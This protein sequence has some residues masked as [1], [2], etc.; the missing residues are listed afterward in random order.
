MGDMVTRL[1]CN[2]EHVDF[3]L[4]SHYFFSASG[5]TAEQ[6]QEETVS[7]FRGYISC[8]RILA[9]V[10]TQ[11]SNTGWKPCRDTNKRE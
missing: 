3:I 10:Q 9:V 7:C 8:E 2:S 1:Q 6:K 4:S 11:W 5:V